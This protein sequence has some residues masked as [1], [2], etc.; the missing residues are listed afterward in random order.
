M[1]IINETGSLDQ[2]LRRNSKSPDAV[3]ASFEC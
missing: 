3:F 2:I 1:R